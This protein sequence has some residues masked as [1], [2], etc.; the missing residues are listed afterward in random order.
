MAWTAPDAAFDERLRVLLDDDPDAGWRAFID[1]YT[2]ALLASIERAGI[3]DRD[4][5]MEI[6]V[7]VC[8]RL[9]SHDCATLRRRDPAKGSLRGWLG[10]V[11][12][13][14][15]VDWVRSRV[16][17]RR[18]FGAVRDLDRFHQRLFELYYWEGRSPAEA[19]QILAMEEK[20]A[21]SLGTVLDALQTIDTA[22][23][24]RH[25]S[26][27]L[28]LAARSRPA[29]SLDDEDAPPID[30]V[31][32]APTPEAA[33]QVREMEEHLSRALAAL[34]PEDAA[35]VSLKFGEGL[36]RA[37]VQRLLRLPEL[38][39]HRVRSIL[40]ALRALLEQPGVLAPAD[41]L[42]ANV[43]PGNA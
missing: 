22:L 20:T 21:V 36:T 11:I 25:R 4:E 8:E 16:G 12:R 14:T 1:Q 24:A 15:V 27:L 41:G 29:A 19:A 31:A 9:S 10:V 42:P 17:R 23:T 34:P 43:K 40:S 2:P 7:L 35:I 37:Q 30:V 38:S 28:S 39:E 18:L 32:A 3:S 6:Y 5:A 26:E 33:L 13:R